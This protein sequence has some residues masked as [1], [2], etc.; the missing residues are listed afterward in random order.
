MTSPD[1]MLNSIKQTLR[2]II[3]EKAT[4]KT[5]DTVAVIFIAQQAYAAKL[6]ASILE[7]EQVKE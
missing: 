5:N 3:R 2:D 1:K 4:E 7:L 6:Y